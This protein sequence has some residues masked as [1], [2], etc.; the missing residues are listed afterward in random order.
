MEWA[1]DGQSKKADPLI[2]IS[3]CGKTSHA[4]ELAMISCKD[5]W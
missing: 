2:V 1:M 5:S 4:T 3:L